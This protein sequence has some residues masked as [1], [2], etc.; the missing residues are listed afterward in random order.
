MA[1]PGFGLPP[2]AGSKLPVWAQNM[3][4]P[5][6]LLA[7]DAIVAPSP[8]YAKEILTPEFGSGLGEFLGSRKDSVYGILNGINTEQWNPQTD[9]AIQSNYGLDDLDT[10]REN[11]AALVREFGLN[12]DP[13]IPL[14]VM[15]T[16]MDP[17]KGVDLV[18]G[19]LR[20]TTDR[21]W[22]AVLLGTGQ[23]HIEKEVKALQAELPSRVQALIRYDAALSHRLY[24]GADLLL[25]PSRYEP[26]GLNQMIAMRYGCVP[27]ARSVGG[28]SDTIEDYDQSSASNGFLFKAA[29]SE[30]LAGALRRALDV[31]ARPADWRDLQK[32]G[33]QQDFSW[34]RSAR[35]YRDVYIHIRSQSKSS[36]P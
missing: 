2:A 10:R 1:L 23:P 7:A 6:G 15:I 21:L 16:R 5:L 18:P 35:H 33:M 36:H 13:S 11:K 12:P 28:L 26:C 8:T 20:Q 4:L 9:Q 29:S 22:Q 27:L 14:L 24:A 17:Q 31:Y 34:E 25:M 3:P 19:A 32:R 30:A